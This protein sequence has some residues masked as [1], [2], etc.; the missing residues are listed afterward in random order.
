MDGK[1]T[2]VPRAGIA[3][4]GL[5]AMAGWMSGVSAADGALVPAIVVED[6]GAELP[7]F[8]PSTDDF[9]EHFAPF[10][11]PAAVIL[12]HGASDEN[13]AIKRHELGL[14]RPVIVRYV[15]WLEH[16]LRGDLGDSILSKQPVSSLISRALPITV[17]LSLFSLVIAIAIAVPTVVLSALKRNTW[18]DLVC[19]TWAFLGVSIPSFWLAIVLIYVFGVQLEW[20]PL[21][22][23]VKP[24]DDFTESITSMVLPAP[25]PERTRRW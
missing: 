10:G 16:V 2:M 25:S 3:A 11:D 20:V 9:E 4:L 19:T 1:S 21:Q 13:L 17:Y 24:Q 23:Y 14:D 12:G 8:E 15:A 7:R 22:G 18:I 5:L 6:G